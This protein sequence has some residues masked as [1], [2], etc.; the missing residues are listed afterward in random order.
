MTA[1]V[2]DHEDPHCHDR[3]TQ[4]NIAKDGSIQCRVRALPTTV[5]MNPETDGKQLRNLRY[6]LETLRNRPEKVEKIDLRYKNIAF[7]LENEDSEDRRSD[8]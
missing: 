6:L 2:L 4:I 3:I 5:V 8:N 7:V 1:L